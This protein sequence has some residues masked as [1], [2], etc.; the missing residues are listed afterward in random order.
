MLGILR[1]DSDQECSQ[2][3]EEVIETFSQLFQ[4]DPN[5]A[6]GANFSGLMNEQNEALVNDD[7]L[8]PEQR[9]AF[10]NA[11]N[12]DW[13]REY[14]ENPNRD[15]L[16]DEYARMYFNPFSPPSVPLA[17]VYNFQPNNPFEHDAD[18]FSVG[19]RLFTEGNLKQSVLALEA[20][21]QADDSNA[22]AWELLGYAN[23]ESDSDAHAI[24][25]LRRVTALQPENSKALM[26][27]TT[28]LINETENNEAMQVL[29]QWFNTHSLYRSMRKSDKYA[30]EEFF[31]LLREAVSRYPDCAGLHARSLFANFAV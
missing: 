10:A 7:D 26:Q 9:D 2:G 12:D 5:D 30:Q 4:L 16:M 21:V 20:A 8:T 28:S 27:L 19:A 29:A 18:A 15:D 11:F 24:Y 23:A 3:N 31:R 1:L 13:I 14:A 22:E 17:T 25:C 6:S